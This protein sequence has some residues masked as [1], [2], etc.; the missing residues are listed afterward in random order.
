MLVLAAWLAW[1]SVERLHFNLAT[2][3]GLR[4]TLEMAHLRSLKQHDLD[5]CFQIRLQSRCRRRTPCFNIEWVLFSQGDES[6]ES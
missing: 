1:C 5:S 4:L 2:H 6:A 3:M